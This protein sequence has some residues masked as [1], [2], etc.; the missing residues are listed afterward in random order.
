[1][2][3][4][5]FILCCALIG[6]IAGTAVAGDRRDE[7]A[8]RFDR[9]VRLFNEGDNANALLEF[10]RAYEMSGER[11]ILLNIGLVQAE[12]RRAVD[13]VATLDQ[14][15]AQAAGINETQKARAR[16]VRDEQK[17]RIGRLMVTTNVEAQI[18]VDN[19]VVGRTPLTAPIAVSSG[20]RLLAVVA[21]GKLPI[22]QEVA[23]T[24]GQQASVSLD[25]MPAQ[26][27]LA[28][29]MV[30]SALPGA[31]VM[32]DGKL[33]GRT[34]LPASIT[35]APGNHDVTLRRA[36]YRSTAQTISLAEGSTGEIS[37]EAIEDPAAADLVG[38]FVSLDIN[39][40]DANVNIDG[41]PRSG[42]KAGLRLPTGPHRLSVVRAGFL[43]FDRELTI[44]KGLPRTVHI[45]LEPTEETRSAH[46]RRVSAQRRNAYITMGVGLVVGGA[47][48]YWVY[49]KNRDDQAAADAALAD[50]NRERYE[51]SG[52]CYHV[53]GTPPLPTA[54][55]EACQAAYDRANQLQDESKWQKWVGWGAV[56][57]GSAAFLTGV[58]LRLMADDPDD[59]RV[60]GISQVQPYAWTTPTGS[61]LGVG[62]TF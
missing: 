58:V 48:G 30:R 9:G 52:N 60:A 28:N 10:K 23:I 44:D 17:T 36:G 21:P 37:L 8:D 7:A 47:G 49:K 26:G 2:R 41:A 13:A 14:L 12:L 11:S 24:G 46:L 61:G 51:P 59:F 50:F 15:L 27:S 3:G 31:D 6:L 39:Q 54:T 35:L 57:V 32:V 29:L 55:Q 53:P 1:M 38:G 43:P 5:S 19:L 25:L 18:E 34:P 22:R 40:D 56:G 16:T 33:V 4:I 62:G 20:L 45:K 42:L